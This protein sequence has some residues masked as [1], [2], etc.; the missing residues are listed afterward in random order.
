MDMPFN[1]NVHAT[2]TACKVGHCSLRLVANQATTKTDP[3][4]CPGPM[5]SPASTPVGSRPPSPVDAQA[6][7]IHCMTFACPG[8]VEKV[9]RFALEYKCA[10]RFNVQKRESYQI[11]NL[12]NHIYDYHCAS[13]MADVVVPQSR[14]GSVESNAE[15]LDSRQVVF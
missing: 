3:Q 12:N 11:I 1:M 15:P 5:S 7:H 8:C 6:C 2:S 4:L 13:C 9:G 10:K 14:R